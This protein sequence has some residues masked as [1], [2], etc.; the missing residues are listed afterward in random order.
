VQEFIL[1]LLE[2]GILTNLSGISLYVNLFEEFRLRSIESEVT[3]SKSNF[4]AGDD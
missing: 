1:A 4:Q 3:H 2:K